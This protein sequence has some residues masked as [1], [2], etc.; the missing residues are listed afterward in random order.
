MDKTFI[1][2]IILLIIKIGILVTI[3]L[4]L[5][6][7]YPVMKNSG[8]DEPTEVVQM[9]SPSIDTNEKCKEYFE[10]LSNGRQEYM[11]HLILE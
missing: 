5:V 2:K 4:S 9:G 10:K 8:K 3:I 6:W 7:L 11:K 1:S